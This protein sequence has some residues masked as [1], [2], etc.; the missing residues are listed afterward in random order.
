MSGGYSCKCDESTRAPKYRR[1]TVMQYRCNH[2]AFSGY[3]YTHSDYSEI[4]CDVCHAR[5][6]TKAAYVEVLGTGSVPRNAEGK[7]IAKRK[8]VAT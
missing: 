4:R 2:S 8:E 7:M 6:R 3:H 5:W 1:W